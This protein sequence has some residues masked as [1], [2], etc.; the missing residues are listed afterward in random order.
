M[1]PA[2]STTLP[3]YLLSHFLT[4]L[5]VKTV[6]HVMH[7]RLLLNWE[8]P[9]G[10]AGGSAHGYPV[11]TPRGRCVP[12]LASQWSCRNPCLHPVEAVGG[13]GSL[14]ALKLVVAVLPFACGTLAACRCRRLWRV[15]PCGP[16]AG[17]LALQG[18][19][20]PGRVLRSGRSGLQRK[21]MQRLWFF[22]FRQGCCVRVL[23][24]ALWS[25]CGVRVSPDVGAHGGNR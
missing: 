11:A 23:R 3:L 1:C 4:P 25:G 18:S 12:A 6:Q 13:Q 20:P 21:K 7:V 8:P 5:W 16:S 14:G 10:R 2:E 19:A 17:S 22:S 24:V 9:W 15:F